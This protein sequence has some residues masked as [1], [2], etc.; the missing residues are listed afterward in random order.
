MNSNSV[1]MEQGHELGRI[2]TCLSDKIQEVQ[3]ELPR[4]LCLMEC[5]VRGQLTETLKLK[6]RKRISDGVTLSPD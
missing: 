2:D 4:D 3:E 1:S 6:A 5:C